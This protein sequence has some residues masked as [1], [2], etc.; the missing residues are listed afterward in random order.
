MVVCAIALDANAQLVV[1]N[2]VTPEYLVQNV[3]LG[4]GVTVSNVTFNGVP[5][6]T[7]NVQI[8]SFDGSATTIGMNTGIVLSSGDINVAV[9]PNNQGAATLAPPVAG[10]ND[11]DLDLA[12]AST[13]FDRAVLE[14]DFVPSGDSLT[15]NYVFGSEE[16]LEWVSAGFNDVFGF[17]LSGPGISG[18]YSGGA[19]N[20]ALIPGTS[21]PVS[22]DNVNDVANSSYYV[23]N[24]DGSTAPFNVD[25][26]YV[27]FDGTTVVLT[28]Y[29]QVQCGQTYHIKIA[30]A[31]AGDPI[32]DS[33]VFLEAG[34]FSSPNQIQLEVVTAS[35]DG[36]LTEG[37]TDAIFTISRPGSEDSIEVSVVVAGTAINGTDY[38][39]LPTVITLPADSTSVSFPVSAFEDGLPEGTETITLTAT[40]V[41]ACGDT[42]VSSATVPIVDY[43]PMVLSTGDTLT[44]CVPEPVAINAWVSGGFEAV[45]LTWDDGTTGSTLMVPGD[46][47]GNYTVTANDECEKSISAVVNVQSGCD[48]IIPNVFSPNNDGENDHFVIQGIL[49]T[50]NKV[51][52]FNRWGQIVFE[53]SNYNNNWDA[54]DVSDGTYYYEVTVAGETES[55]YTGHLTILDT[56]N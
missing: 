49:G 14:F 19:A 36:T 6:T 4:G 37:C 20:I 44:N 41:N 53:A 28:A 50:I 54:R 33:G 3:L 51:R 47:D 18:P 7:P 11:P 16:Y 29:A 21:T 43:V 25:S 48:I 10:P 32:L 55:P 52:I 31:D 45:T 9:G 56:G 12:S 17:F 42:S 1:D 38:T 5:G 13:T 23:D 30:I 35:A 24:G 27:Q 15:F 40:F 39:T 26:Q 34:S 2:T 22:I 46:A 8:G